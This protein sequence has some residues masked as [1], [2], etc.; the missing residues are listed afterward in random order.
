MCFIFLL[1]LSLKRT[2]FT[3]NIQRI[4]LDMRAETHMDLQVKRPFKLSNLNGN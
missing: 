1:Q 4:T 3:I 2:I